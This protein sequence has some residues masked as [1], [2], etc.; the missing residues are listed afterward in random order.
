M[1]P[2]GTLF[3]A[4]FLRHNDEA[5]RSRYGDHWLGFEEDALLAALQHAGFVP[6]APRREP[7]GRGLTLLLLTARAR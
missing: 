1:S 4:D 7:V 5:M 6:A 3:L 2:G